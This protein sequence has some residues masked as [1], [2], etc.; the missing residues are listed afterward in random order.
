MGNMLWGCPT[1]G[2]PGAGGIGAPN[3]NSALKVWLWTL[4]IIGEISVFVEKIL[5]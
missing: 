4:E 1:W 3:E 2:A 5:Y